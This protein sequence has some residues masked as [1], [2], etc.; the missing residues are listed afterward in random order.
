MI[1]DQLDV[2]T[3]GKTDDARE[4]GR[5]PPPHLFRSSWSLSRPYQLIPEK[6]RAPHHT[7]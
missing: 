5:P 2:I 3:S 6:G 4:T 7:F 1:D